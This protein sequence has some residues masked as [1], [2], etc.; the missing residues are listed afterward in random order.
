MKDRSLGKAG[1]VAAG[2][3]C[4][5]LAAI[6]IVV[7]L[8]PTTPFLLL[9]AAL[10]AKSSDRWY[11][12]L[13]THRVFG[14]YVRNYREHRAATRAVKAWTL[15][16][17]WVTVSFAGFFVERSLMVRILLAAIALGVSAHILSLKTLRPER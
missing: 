3:A 15:L 4:V 12:W 10:F 13:T 7:P 11:A 8:L 9:A 1:L 16:V 5:A 14:P 6:G 17:L 2:L